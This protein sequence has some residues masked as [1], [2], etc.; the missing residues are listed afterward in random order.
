M[1]QFIFVRPAI[2]FIIVAQRG[3]G[4]G[5]V[6][7]GCVYLSVCLWWVW[8]VVCM[9]C[10]YIVWIINAPGNRKR[11]CTLT[12]D[13]RCCFQ[14]SALPHSSSSSCHANR[15]SVCRICSAFVCV[16]IS[17]LSCGAW[18]ILLLPH[19]LWTSGSS[20]H[21]SALCFWPHLAVILFNVFSPAC[22]PQRSNV[23]YNYLHK[24]V[25]LALNACLPPPS[26]L[27]DC[28]HDWLWCVLFL[29][30]FI[31]S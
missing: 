1:C 16:F 22:L 15:I 5:S 4:G 3:E 30:T 19:E 14:L 9:F 28:A 23:C 31:N 2:I 6:F 18:R 17:D 21:C 27:P 25:T 20:A 7:V 10:V 11:S 24:C 13:W 29:D 8:S 26:L 12:F